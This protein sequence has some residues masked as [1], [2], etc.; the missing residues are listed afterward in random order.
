M[1]LQNT[2]ETI[3]LIASAVV[4]WVLYSNRIPKDFAPKRILVVKLDHIG[5]VLLATPVFSNLRKSFPDTELHAL[6]GKW[7]RV[8]LDNHPHV[9]RVI[10]YNSPIFCRTGHPATFRN[11]LRLFKLLRRQ[12]YDMLIELRGDWRIIWYSLLR[13]TPMRL[14]RASLQ[15]AHKLGLHR[16]SGLHET[17][18]NLDVLN[19]VGIP[20][21][22]QNTT[23]S[24]STIDKEWAD[25][26]FTKVNFVSEF[27]VVSIH[28]GSP[29][30]L[31]R[32]IPGRFA[33]LADWLIEQK[34]AQIVFVG[35]QDEIS[36]IK[37][38]QNQM[39]GESTN[40]AGK[41]SIPQLASI[42]QKSDMFIGNDSGPMHLAAAVGTQ[43]IGLFGPGN[44]HR[45]GPVGEKC[46]II[47]K[48]HDCPP[49]SGNKCRY[50]EE[51]CMSKIRVPDVIE[52]LE[53]FEYFR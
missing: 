7:S 32:W 25:N 10:E 23:F 44:P 29:N 15:I 2:A 35:V 20:T 33:E 4:Q 42:L 13:F 31:K 1:I 39:R 5:D 43:T 36:I 27:P 40:I 22:I 30:I 48:K 50:G 9:D 37:H 38:I 26:L 21:T 28:P 12:N 8:I 45:F 17:T 24:I 46:Q 18:R 3:R 41:T 16:L 53:K 51:G 11:A 6:C 52:I 14:C 19:Q 47:Q 49:C 34:E